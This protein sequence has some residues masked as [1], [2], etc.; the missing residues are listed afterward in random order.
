MA[1]SRFFRGRSQSKTTTM[2][3]LLRKIAWVQTPTGQ[4]AAPRWENGHR[5]TAVQIHAERQIPMTTAP[6]AAGREIT[7]PHYELLTGF[8]TVAKAIGCLRLI[9]ASSTG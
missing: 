3:T 8:E 9:R 1:W 4:S 7:V 5:A 2:K 6:D